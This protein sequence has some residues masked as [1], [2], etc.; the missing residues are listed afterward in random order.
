MDE[1]SDRAVSRG[2]GALVG[3]YSAD[4]VA[5]KCSSTSI[6][7]DAMSAVLVHRQEISPIDRSVDR[8]ELLL[9]LA[10]LVSRGGAQRGSCALRSDDTDAFGAFLWLYVAQVRF[11][12]ATLNS[13][14]DVCHPRPVNG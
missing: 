11:N 7:F 4:P 5:K 3:H 8:P 2:S 6:S 14:L 12:A 1:R 9:E 13:Q 10:A